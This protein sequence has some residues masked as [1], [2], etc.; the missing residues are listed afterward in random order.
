[1]SYTYHPSIFRLIIM[2]IEWSATPSYS[3]GPKL[4]SKNISCLS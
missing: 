4:E 2:D 1:M 3:K